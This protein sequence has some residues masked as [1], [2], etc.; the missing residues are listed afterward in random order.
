MLVVNNLFCFK[1][2]QKLFQ[3]LDLLISCSS[4]VATMFGVKLL[5]STSV[6]E[7]HVDLRVQAFL[8]FN[9]LSLFVSW[10]T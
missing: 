1:A 4:Y 7:S 6:E 9:K 8:L 2:F 10:N 5:L 3:N